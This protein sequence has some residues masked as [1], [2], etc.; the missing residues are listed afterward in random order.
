MEREFKTNKPFEKSSFLVLTVLE[1]MS[2]VWN[3]CM[4]LE[5]KKMHFV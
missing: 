5:Y 4:L 3:T 2:N 1:D